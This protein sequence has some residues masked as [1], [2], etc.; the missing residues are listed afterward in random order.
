[1]R[2]LFVVAMCIVFFNDMFGQSADSLETQKNLR[3]IP[4]PAIFYTPETR[5]G[6][7]ALTTGIFN[8]GDKT[9]TRAS[10]VQVLGAY[11]LND[12]I[13]FETSHNIFTKNE[14]WVFN[15]ALNYYDF[16]IFYYGIGNDTN[17]D[18]EED[19]E[20]QVF[21]FRE[22][23]LKKVRNHLFAGLQV[24]Y[25]DLYDLDFEPKFLIADKP[26][27]ESQ[28]GKNAAIGF[29]VVYDNRD[30]VLNA[31]EG[32]FL[33]VASFH[34]QQAFGSDFT[35][36]RYTVDLRK[37][38]GL[39]DKSVLA[40]QFFGEFNSSN[41]PF[42]EMALMGG[43]MIM[44]GYYNGRYRDNQQ[45]ALQGEYRY[46]VLPKLGFTVFS[47]MGDVASELSKFDMGDFKWAAGAGLRFMVNK[48]DRANIR[49]DYGI[50]DGVSGFYFAF[51][52]AF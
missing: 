17:E 15:G 41:V 47:A 44:R 29:S 52:E 50:G 3:I 27:L 7:G 36:N 51:A 9:T 5:L 39:T 14:E 2:G 13:I 19:L 21:E 16:P 42:R 49:I 35:Y 37:F 43:D 28:T 6:Y 26:L 18:F 1:M 4:L 20:Y 12:Q 31:T 38:W 11:T 48:S 33:N 22:R 30:N 8:L 46:Q 40:A 34:H 10:N 32:M 45:M 24:R 25:T 23:V